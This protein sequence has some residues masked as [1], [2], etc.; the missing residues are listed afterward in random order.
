MGA[1]TVLRA[2][3]VWVLLLLLAIANGV[4]REA[5]LIPRLGGPSGLVLSGLLLSALI[6]VL[7]WW[8]LPWIGV[9]GHGPL[10]VFVPFFIFATIGGMISLHYMGR[11][12]EPPGMIER[13]LPLGPML[14]L[15]FQ[16]VQFRKLLRFY[17]LWTLVTAVSTPF[18]RPQ[19]INHLQM[20]LEVIPVCLLAVYA[21]LAGC[22]L[23]AIRGRARPA[24]AG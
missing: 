22:Y 4:L 11:K 9:R 19:M 14:R 18:W 12:W 2:L 13:S 6:L 23:V 7:A 15:P 20:S 24:P 17:V 10:L 5:V 8:L 3:L 16:H 1:M 21:A